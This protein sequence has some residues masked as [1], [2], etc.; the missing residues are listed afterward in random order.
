MVD[1]E[2][3]RKYKNLSLLCHCI[4]TLPHGN[5][6]PERGFSINKAILAVH[7]FSIKE[8]TLE[9]LRLVKDFLILNGGGDEVE[10]TKELRKSCE[11]SHARY[12]CYLSQQKKIEE[13]EAARKKTE[14][15]LKQKKDEIESLERER[16]ILLKSIKVA[17]NCIEEGNI[18]LESIT[19]SKTINRDKLIGAQ[20]KISMGI[21]R[22]SE[23]SQE[24]NELEKKMKR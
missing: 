5:A 23:L 12:K 4:L 11:A 16:E 24:L 3:N 10:V 20:T 9:A 18:E 1:S 21:K 6:E 15:E 8:D 17:D 2:G 14:E 7:G 19:K 13:E 22:K